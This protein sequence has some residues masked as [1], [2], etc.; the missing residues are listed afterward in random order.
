MSNKKKIEINKE[1]VKKTLGYRV[2][3]KLL[4]VSIPI[5]YLIS[6]CFALF[7]GYTD[8]MNASVYASL[9]ENMDAFMNKLMIVCLLSAVGIYG[10]NSFAKAARLKAINAEFNKVFD[11]ALHSK[12]SDINKLTPERISGLVN[13]VAVM[14]ADIKSYIIDLVK[15]V[16]PFAIVVYHIA[17][18]SWY[19]A[20]I[21]VLV[22]GLVIILN[23]YSD[24]LFH[25]DSEKSVMSN[26]MRGVSTALFMSVPMLKY[27]NAEAWAQKKLKDA[28]NEATPAMQSCAKQLYN[29][30]VELLSTIPE[31]VCM[32]NAIKMGDVTLATFMGFNLGSIYQMMYLLRGMAEEKSELDGELNSMAE[33]K[34][35]DKAY[36]DKPAFPDKLI[37]QN[38][39][40]YYESD[41][42][43]RKPFIFNNLV[44][45]KGKKYR[46]TACSGAG[47]AEPYSNLI[48]TDTPEGYTRMGDLKVGDKV[49]G[50]NGFSTEVTHIFEQGERDVYKVTFNDGRSILVSDEHLFGVWVQGH[51]KYNYKVKSL[52][53]MMC[54]YKRE[55][56]EHS[57]QYT[58]KYILPRTGPVRREHKDVPIDPWILG[59]FIGNG[60]CRERYLT[61]SAGSPEVPMKIAQKLKCYVK[62][63]SMHNYNY[64]FYTEPGRPIP[65]VEFFKDIPDMINCYSYDKRIPRDY[66]V[67]DISTRMELLR[68]LMDT[69]G[70]ID[71]DYRYHVTYSTTSKGLVE[72]ISELMYSLGFSVGI[73][74]DKRS[75]KYK[76]GYC[77]G[78][79]FKVPHKF[80]RHMF[81]VGYKKERAYKALKVKTTKRTDSLF[82]YN[83][84]PIITNIEFSH[85]EKCRCIMVEN[86]EHLYMTGMNYIV[87]HNSSVF[88]YFAGE[89]IT[90]RQPDFR[91]F[92][93]HQ[94]ACLINLVS[95]RDNIT[96]GNQ[97]VPDGDIVYLLTEMGMGDWLA[98][99]PKG[100]DSIIGVDVTPSGGESSRI[101]LMRAFLHVRNYG[102]DPLH[103]IRNTSDLIMMDEVTSAL[104]K[105]T[106]WLAD[107]ELCTEEKVIKLCEKEFAGCTVAIISHEDETSHA[108][109]FRN[110]VDY[111]VRLEIRQNGDKEEHIICSAEPVNY[112][113]TRSTALSRV[114]K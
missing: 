31:I 12:I 52:S 42:N 55:Y 93:V 37:L 65:T 20:V 95:L 47:K 41:E 60:C 24:F 75:E 78:I 74:I 82:S 86:V 99:L 109:G 70:S 53:E 23:L 88:K 10:L 72:D 6:I 43:K 46:F 48:P 77:A 35:D 1:D 50:R 102:P 39:R 105:R 32:G 64:V 49:F 96:L 56:P 94:Q 63:N 51:S 27:M 14:K 57:G 8:K 89:M 113:K 84:G 13:S 87:T 34:G 100:L 71:N 54:D 76:S 59:C 18:I 91:T 85:K 44:I 90:D 16:I 79:I 45:R 104:D 98:N 83:H 30:G 106:R 101:S 58:Y 9:T 19:A 15:A 7:R 97:Y 38:V 2:S 22:M 92:Y 67:N 61:I 73:S 40:F 108:Y 110:I 114:A 80:K 25:F 68:G 111:E 28:Q 29:F 3:K 103:R 62:R 17:K 112:E 36:Q 81:T 11:N 5:L 69:D 66:I 4:S 26:E 33:L 107:D 21:M